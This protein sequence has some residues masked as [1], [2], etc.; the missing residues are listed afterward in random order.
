MQSYQRHFLLFA[1]LALILAAAGFLFNVA[2]DTVHAAT[3]TKK[4][5]AA[6]TT[7]KPAPTFEVS[8]WIPY[9]RTATG[10]QDVLPHLTQLSEV[11]PFGYTVKQDGSLFDA[12]GIGTGAWDA[13]IATAR[14]DKV[15]VIP[16]VMW[17]DTDSIHTVLS[18]PTLRATHEDAIVAMVNQNNFDG[19]DIDY[20][21]KKAEDINNFSKFLKELYAKMGK[22][23]VTCTIEARTP[24]DSRYLGAAPADATQYA[25]DLTQINKYCDRVKLMTYDQEAVDLKLGQKYQNALYAPIADPVWVAKVVALMSKSISKSKIELGVATYGYIYQVVPQ[26]D[27]TYDYSLLE[28]FNPKYGT[29]LAASLNIIPTRNIAGELSFSYV[30]TTLSS[31]GLPSQQDLAAAAPPGT[32]SSLLAAAGATQLATTQGKQAPFYLLWWSDSKAIADKVALAK[33]L[34]VRGVAVF[35]MDGGEDPNMWSVLP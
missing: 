18:N 5:T 24:V 17:S 16:T 31:N 23:L 8:G 19:V 34:G 29:E 20:E 4:A 30:P 25:N 10:T 26:S 11:N 27:G 35:K 22:K 15:R 2:P 28:A 12:A 33:K 3:T 21:G 7:A 14:T 1:E 6:T 32:S 9:W 13:F